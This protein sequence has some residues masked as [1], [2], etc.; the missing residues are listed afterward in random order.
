MNLRKKKLP[1]EDNKDAKYAWMSK[2]GCAERV[3]APFVCNYLASSVL[4][5]IV[6]LVLGSHPQE[7]GFAQERGHGELSEWYQIDRENE[8]NLHA[9]VEG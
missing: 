3:H 2:S 8:G 7:H 6:W 5:C 4:L 9:N 1:N